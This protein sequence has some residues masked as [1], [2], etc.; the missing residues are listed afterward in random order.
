MTMA[1]SPA[2]W[3]TCS[4]RPQAA[5]NAPDTAPAPGDPLLTIQQLEM[6]IQQQQAAL[7]EL[8][9]MLGRKT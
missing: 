6:T 1:H 3:R 4:S 7:A 2:I 8:R 9:E 5:D